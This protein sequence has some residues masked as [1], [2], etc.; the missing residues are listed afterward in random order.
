MSHYHVIETM[1][2]TLETAPA[3]SDQQVARDYANDLAKNW[4]VREPFVVECDRTDCSYV[5]DA[6]LGGEPES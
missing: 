1:E 6:P 2:E 5:P 3:F 4:A